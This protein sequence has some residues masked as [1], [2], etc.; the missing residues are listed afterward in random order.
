MTL[1]KRYYIWLTKAYVKK[2]KKTIFWSIGIGAAVFFL[3]GLLLNLYV[4]PLIQKRVQKI[5]YWG[6]YTASTISDTILKDVSY[7]LTKID[8]SGKITQ[9]AAYKWSVQDNGKKYTFFLRKNQYF[10]NGDELTAENIPI[11]FKDV[12]TKAIDKYTIELSLNNPYSPFLSTVSKPLILES[13]YG[14]G[15]YKIKKIQLNAGFVKSLELQNKKERDR[16]KIIFF[17]PTQNALKIAYALGEVDTALGLSDTNIEESNFKNWNNTLISTTIDYSELVS[18]FYNNVSGELSNKKLRQALNYALPEKFSA[19]ERAYS[20]IPPISIYFSKSPN[21]GISDISIAQ[22]LISEAPD[23]NKQIELTTTQE[24][25]QSAKEV[26]DAWKKIG[27]NTKIKIVTD[28]PK[29]FEVFL[30]SYKVP[31]DP[32]QYTLWH[33]SQENNI[34][35]YKSL[36]I[37]KLLEDGRSTTDFEKRISFYSDF[38][39]YLIDDVP[40]SFLYFP[41]KYTLIRK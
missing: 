2:W 24:Y 11:N 17:Y 8:N 26:Q 31:A 40:A 10:H 36:R 18:I 19:G 6:T 34:T 41:N 12:T 29:K 23:F 25:E 39:K 15:D 9:G 16:K 20:P 5:G 3:V 21:Y 27:I 7:G 14:L 32:D 30:Y 38:Q 33:S 22:S 4:F 28:F 35:N 37:D 1:R 13:E